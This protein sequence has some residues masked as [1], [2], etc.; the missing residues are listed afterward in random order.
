MF[1]ETAT[2]PSVPMMNSDSVIVE[3][4]FD[5]QV[6]DHFQLL[7]DSRSCFLL[8][9]LWRSLD[10]SARSR[11]EEQH[12]SA[13]SAQNLKTHCR[14]WNVPVT[15]AGWIFRRENFTTE[16]V[17]AL[18]VRWK[19]LFLGGRFCNRRVEGHVFNTVVFKQLHWSP[20]KYNEKIII[21]IQTNHWKREEKASVCVP[22]AELHAESPG[23]FTRGTF[24]QMSCKRPHHRVIVTLKEQHDLRNSCISYTGGVRIFTLILGFS[25]NLVLAM[26]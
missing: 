10:V 6:E 25:I 4:L 20:E 3:N 18:L 12:Q 2:S 26:D 8:C 1:G 23:P 15:Q 17:K 19:D 9:V 5:K 21:F 22:S 11:F 14:L 24:H 13:S 16:L 7:I